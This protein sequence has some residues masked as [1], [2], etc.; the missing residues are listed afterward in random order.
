[1]YVRFLFLKQM[2]WK[3]IVRKYHNKIWAYVIL[4]IFGLIILLVKKI[5]YSKNKR[6][7]KN[8]K[9]IE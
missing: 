8:I 4:A 5:I 1:M 2:Q 7:S 9:Y 6:M 3:W